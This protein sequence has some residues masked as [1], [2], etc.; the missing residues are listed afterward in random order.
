MGVEGNICPICSREKMDSKHLFL[1]RGRFYKLRTRVTN[2]WDMNFMGASNL[3][4]SFEISFHAYPR[5]SKEHVWQLAFS[6]L[7]WAIWK[8]WNRV[9]FFSE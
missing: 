9:V 6:A 3:V 2:L 5:G 7:I 4:T 1:H 8:T